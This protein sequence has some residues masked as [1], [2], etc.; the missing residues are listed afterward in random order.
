M[1]LES[2]SARAQGALFRAAAH[3]ALY[4]LSGG[5][6]EEQREQAA[7]AVAEMQRL[8]DD[9]API[10]RYFPPTFIRFVSSEG[11]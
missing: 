5:D 2:D 3:F 6:D 11:S 9:V 10:P 4:R 8:G 1:T 7:A